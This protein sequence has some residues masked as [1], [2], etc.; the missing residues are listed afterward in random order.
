M[1]FRNINQ[2]EDLGFQGCAGDVAGIVSGS[3][4]IDPREK[5]KARK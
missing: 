1:I 5:S 4:S 3:M 2:K